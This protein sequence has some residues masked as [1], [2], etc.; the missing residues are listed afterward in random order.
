MDKAIALAQ[1]RDVLDLMI[2]NQPGLFTEPNAVAR[3]SGAKL[4]DFCH[5]FMAQYAQRLVDRK[6]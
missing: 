4:A 3:A 1:A 5:D 6:D 2:K